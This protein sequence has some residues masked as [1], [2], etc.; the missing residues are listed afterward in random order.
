MPGGSA[1]DIKELEAEASSTRAVD[2]RL[3]NFQRELGNIVAKYRVTYN[4]AVSSLRA[5]SSFEG[6]QPLQMTAAS[7][8]AT[9]GSR[10]GVQMSR[11][12]KVVWHAWRVYAEENLSTV[13]RKSLLEGDEG[14]DMS[15]RLFQDLSIYQ[16]DGVVT[17]R[18]FNSY[19]TNM[20][21]SPTTCD[22]MLQLFGFK[23]LDHENDRTKKLRAAEK[24]ELVRGPHARS[25]ALAARQGYRH[26]YTTIKEVQRITQLLMT[27]LRK[28]GISD[29]KF[30]QVFLGG[31]KAQAA[32]WRQDVAIPKLEEENIDYFNPKRTSHKNQLESHS[33]NSIMT[34]FS[35]VLVF[36]IA[37]ESRAL[38]SMLDA[39]QYICSGAKVIL[40]ISM[41]Q[42]GAFIGS[43]KCGKFQAKDLN[44]SRLYLEDVCKRHGC[45]VF[46]D[47]GAACETAI[48]MVREKYSAMATSNSDDINE[49]IWTF[50]GRPEYRDECR[51]AILDILE[52]HEHAQ[53]DF[54]VSSIPE[55]DPGSKEN[56]A[57]ATI[58]P[59]K[60]SI[61]IQ[62]PGRKRGLSSPRAKMFTKRDV[63]DAV[64]K[65]VR[66]NL[67]RH[68]DQYK[69][70]LQRVEEAA[71]ILKKKARRA[72]MGHARLGIVKRTI[73]KTPDA[74]SMKRNQSGVAAAS[75]PISA[76]PGPQKRRIAIKIR[77][78]GCAKTR[79]GGAG[80]GGA[81]VPRASSSASV[82]LE[83]KR[84]PGDSS[85]SGG[86]SKG[87][88]V[89]NF[90]KSTSTTNLFD[91]SKDSDFDEKLLMSDRSSRSSR[92]R[93]SESKQPLSANSSPGQATFPEIRLNACFDSAW[94]DFGHAME[95]VIGSRK[96]GD[97]DKLIDFVSFLLLQAYTSDY[98]G[99]CAS[100]EGDKSDDRLKDAGLL[101][102][103]EQ[104]F[105]QCSVEQEESG[106]RKEVPTEIRSMRVR[107]DKKTYNSSRQARKARG[108]RSTENS[109]LASAKV[110]RPHSR[111]SSLFLPE[112]IK[113]PHS[114]GS[115]MRSDSSGR[116]KNLLA[117]CEDEPPRIV[118]VASLG[119]F[120]RSL[121]DKGLTADS[122]RKISQ[123]LGIPLE[124]MTLKDFTHAVWTILYSRT[125]PL[126]SIAVSTEHREFKSMQ[127]S[128]SAVD[129][130]LGGACNPT[131][132]R[133]NIAIPTFEERGIT[134]YN[135][136]VDNWTEELIVLEALVKARSRIL[137][138]VL[139]GQT[140]AISSMIEVTEYIKTGR[141]VVM[142]VQYMPEG[143][144]IRG[145]KLSSVELKELN[146]AR[147]RLRR[148]AERSGIPVFNTVGEACQ[149]ICN[150][151][152]SSKYEEKRLVELL[153]SDNMESIARST[154][155]SYRKVNPTDT[156]SNQTLSFTAICAML[157]DV[158]KNLEQVIRGGLRPP[159]ISDIVR[160][161]RMCR[162]KRSRWARTET[163]KDKALY[164]TA[165]YDTFKEF[166][167]RVT[168]VAVCHAM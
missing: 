96:E 166:V 161:A 167:H 97:L 51:K 37:R 122:A 54:T 2:S 25:R 165:D 102:A 133:K 24:I 70:K 40:S 85:S 34:A 153:G 16:Q 130:F 143:V 84:A 10:F 69:L 28:L 146:G 101:G 157:R 66:T 39:V 162:W 29:P 68:F 20:G 62:I 11:P 137:L 155:Q 26:C 49:T 21:F 15:D 71:S 5:V 138:F 164:Y 32:T 118:K 4:E 87:S 63:V 41:V 139:S 112:P 148:T 125:I 47:I 50:L 119:K 110:A 72:S 44:R 108:V 86:A 35:D 33:L 124:G 60:R 129:V 90:G 132:W 79:P 100:D 48:T 53:K 75:P 140:R 78:G 61:S 113:R 156:A 59:R 116:S 144:C 115:G 57:T 64:A 141:D 136:Q 104:L 131:T 160:I 106:C 123:I 3:D 9:Y 142:V 6:A 17:P 99:H 147:T 126:S 82:P 52:E 103:I 93:K 109:P 158:Y 22:T 45:M 31:S 58:K 154:W 134:F 145:E 18:S 65:S 30:I 114:S 135:P 46:R 95:G 88:N 80:K 19:L 89:P 67:V 74:A 168:R 150:R 56:G 94:D 36:G 128:L 73:S 7:W 8:A 111:T 91:K 14:A 38:V 149:H 23:A 77:P 98:V 107:G 42:E 1:T 117:V 83:M 81:S 121:Q 12:E 163:S 105:E 27:K 120:V 43:D 127:T 55:G 159:H 152:A 151:L 92:D 76:T 13:Y